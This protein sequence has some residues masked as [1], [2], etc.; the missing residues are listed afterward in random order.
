MGRQE[1]E[2]SVG[3]QI[4]SGVDLVET[5]D[6]LSRI[7]QSLVDVDILTAEDLQVYRQ[8]KAAAAALENGGRQSR[9]EK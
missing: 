3:R 6:L 7:V 1:E 9:S 8:T 2:E 5:N 4:M